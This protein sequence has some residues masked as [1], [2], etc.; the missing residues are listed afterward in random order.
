ME[1]GPEMEQEGYIKCLIKKR[2]ERKEIEREKLKP[3]I[4][5]EHRIVNKKAGK[6]ERSEIYG[7]PPRTKI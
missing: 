6:M 7:D 4:Y 2:R 1:S 5:K 3:Q